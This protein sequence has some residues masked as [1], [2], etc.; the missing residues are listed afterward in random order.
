MVPAVVIDRLVGVATTTRPR[1]RREHR[2]RQEDRRAADSAR[3]SPDHIR[4]NI[5]AITPAR[6][7]LHR[8]VT[9]DRDQQGGRVSPCQQCLRIPI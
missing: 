1:E 9:I 7:L 6:L 4:L 8:K 5:H 2:H 3:C